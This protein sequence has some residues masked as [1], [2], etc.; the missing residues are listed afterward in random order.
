[1]KKYIIL[2]IILAV[3]QLG[4]CQYMGSD[5]LI[6]KT[7]SI[8]IDTTANHIVKANWVEFIGN[9]AGNLW[10]SDAA[11]IHSIKTNVGIGINAVSTNALTL[12]ITTGYS[13]YFTGSLGLYT[14]KLKVGTGATISTIGTMA[15]KTFW[16]GTQ[17]AYDA[18]TTKNTNTIYFIEQ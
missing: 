12:N 6:T 3:A 18:I 9:H 15:T 5:D 13:G 1:M 8:A 14:N 4:Y 7:D 16:T 2:L 10:L 17:A 11:G